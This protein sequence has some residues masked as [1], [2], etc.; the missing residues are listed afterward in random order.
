ML[1]ISHDLA[2]VSSIADRVAVMEHGRV[3]EVGDVSVVLR[4]PQHEA[5]RRLIDAVPPHLESDSETLFCSE[6]DFNGRMALT[7]RKEDARGN[8]TT[9][10]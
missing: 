6:K 5:T 1:F 9:Q 3:V 7:R 10:H 8:E 4:R 2:V